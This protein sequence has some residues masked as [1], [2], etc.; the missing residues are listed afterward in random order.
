MARPVPYFR[1]QAFNIGFRNSMG[2]TH[3][4]PSRL[5]ATVHG[6]SMPATVTAHSVSETQSSEWPETPSDQSTAASAIQRRPGHC[7]KDNKK[8]GQ[9]RREKAQQLAIQNKKIVYQHTQA[10]IEIQGLREQLWQQEQSHRRY[11]AKMR[12]FFHDCH[13]EASSLVK[14]VNILLSDCATRP[15]GVPEPVSYEHQLARDKAPM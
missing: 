5:P 8:R 3:V 13:V 4:Q 9:R 11:E 14:S 10:Q 12:R 2:S 6:K 15:R 7:K 1:P